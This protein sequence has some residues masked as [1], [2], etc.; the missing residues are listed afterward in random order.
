MIDRKNSKA[1]MA[2]MADRDVNYNHNGTVIVNDNDTEKNI[3]NTEREST[4]M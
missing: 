1:E 2:K 4:P 3:M